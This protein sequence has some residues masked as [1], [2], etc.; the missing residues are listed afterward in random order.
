M[1]CAAAAAT[2]DVIEREDLLANADAVGSYFRRSLSKLMDRHH[3][4]GDVRGAGL[5]LGIE[6]VSDRSGKVADPNLA[7]AVVNGL[8]ER[9][10]LVSTTGLHGNVVKIRP[11]LVWQEEH[12]DLFVTELDGVLDRLHA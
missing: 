12:V 8:R 11:P 4:I 10:I 2:L 6:V 3:P 7:Q 1:S 9:R 5:F